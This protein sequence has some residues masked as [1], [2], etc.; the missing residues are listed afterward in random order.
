MYRSLL[1]LGALFVSA[2]AMADGAS[3]Y[4][5]LCSSCH[6]TAG[7]GDGAAAAA[8][9]VKPASF[10][11]AAFW[12]SRDDDAVMKVIKEGGAAVGK[13]PM[14]APFGTQ[15]DEAQIKELVEYLK[16]LKK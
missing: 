9:P 10:A 11:D 6:G 14:M 8:L 4:A 2:P 12:E 15:L 1:L 7:A 13:S 16:T 5:S 3:T